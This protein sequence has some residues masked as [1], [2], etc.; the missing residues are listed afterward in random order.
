MTKTVNYFIIVMFVFAQK[1]G[2][3][4]M[5][6]QFKKILATILV[7]SMATSI[8]FP[9]LAEGTVNN[10]EDDTV[11]VFQN[12]G[13][14]QYTKVHKDLRMY[15]NVDTIQAVSL[16]NKDIFQVSEDQFLIPAYDNTYTLAEKIELDST[17]VDN[18]ISLLG[19][20]EI[21]DKLKDD[22]V[23][24]IERENENN[25]DD[26][27]IDLFVPS[28]ENETKSAKSTN[29]FDY[30]GHKLRNVFVEYNNCSTEMIKQNGSSAKNK[31][32]S[33]VNF[34]ISCVGCVSQTIGIFGAGKSALDM[35]IA[36]N[37]PVSVGTSQ[38]KT[39]TS[40]LYN[41][42]T[43]QT[44]CY[45]DS[46]S[47]WEEGCLSRYASIYQNSTYQFYSSNGKDKLIQTNLSTTYISK[48][49]ADYQFAINNAPVCYI[50]PYIYVNLYGTRI[51]L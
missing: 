18:T 51:Q 36:F 17:N 11:I 29:Y 3:I 6:K 30:M 10:F 42:K 28:A 31:A 48:H 46:V 8:G 40:L 2:I 16:E 32:D 9:A 50:D 13:H 4:L 19:T 49:Y 21:S 12:D 7:T 37:G 41:K 35:F 24:N 47:M 45:S 27:Y 5:K 34:T 44:D 1:G 22:I 15:E 39:Y 14:G 25:N 26:F 33:F 38:D 43:M 23:E 20:Y